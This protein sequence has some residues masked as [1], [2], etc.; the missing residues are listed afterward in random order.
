MVSDNDLRRA[1]CI[2]VETHDY[3]VPRTSEFIRR[4]LGSAGFNVRRGA[5][6]ELLIAVQG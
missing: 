4:R 3:L 2:I 6:A 1:R 5:L